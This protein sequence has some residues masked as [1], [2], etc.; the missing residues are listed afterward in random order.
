MLILQIK[1]QFRKDGRP[2][3]C[4]VNVAIDGADFCIKE[5]RPFSASWY[6]H[7]YKGPG[8]RCE[9]GVCIATGWIAWAHGPF[10]CG[11]C[12][13][14]TIAQLGLHHMLDHG[15]RHI[16]DGGCKSLHAIIPDDAVT[17][18]EMNYMQICRTRHETINTLF[19]KFASIGDVFTRHCSKHALFGHSVINI[20]QIGI[21]HG[22]IN[23]FSVYPF[24]WE[25]ATWPANLHGRQ[26]G[27]AR[28]AHHGIQGGQGV[29][30][31]DDNDSIS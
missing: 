10:R 9:I 12:S 30:V 16:A 6:S 14:E 11:T 27:G 19:K 20:V 17:V 3:R 24:E 4:A 15:E 23:P 31:S 22:E 28:G 7:K 18:Q 25:P 8:V 29:F 2:P 26:R 1:W 13:D 5:P 21:M